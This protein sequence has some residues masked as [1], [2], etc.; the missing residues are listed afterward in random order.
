[1]LS[2]IAR[3]ERRIYVIL[4]PS[5]AK[6]EK[7]GNRWVKE[8]EIP[9]HILNQKADKKLDYVVELYSNV[10]DEKVISRKSELFKKSLQFKGF[11]HI[12]YL[13][14]SYSYE[15]RLWAFSY[16]L[17]YKTTID[18]PDDQIG[19]KHCNFKV[20]NFGRKGIENAGWYDNGSGCSRQE[21][22]R[23]LK[24]LNNRLIIDRIVGLDM[25]NI[26]VA[27]NPDILQWSI[28]CK[29][30]IG[31]TT[32]ILIPPVMSLITPRPEECA[33]MLEFLELVADAVT[34]GRNM[35]S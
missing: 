30:L 12:T 1:M 24:M 15:N 35:G 21:T 10:I 16:N 25:T 7:I 33:K 14:L 18:A 22:G 31:S 8:K 13:N 5:M 11:H 3:S 20:K 4:F 2:V 6:E 23:F 28:S 17:N 19:L 9:H 27:Y 32:W 29:T 26:E 34:N